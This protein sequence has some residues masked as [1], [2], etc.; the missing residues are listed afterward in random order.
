MFCG[1]Y[2]TLI[3]YANCILDMYNG[4]VFNMKVFI[5]GATGFIGSFLVEALT[6]KGYQVKCLVRN[7][8]KLN[9]ISDLNVKC[10]FGNL[11]DP[12]SLSKGLYDADYI[13]HLAGVTKSLKDE[14]YISANVRGTKNLI[15]AVLATNKKLKRLIHIS[16][17]AAIGPSPTIEPI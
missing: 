5:T 17:L 6:K 9:W 13:Y 1:I 10:H 11:N 14:N 3:K 2:E 16:S 12:E 7:S 8:S 15:D 4:I